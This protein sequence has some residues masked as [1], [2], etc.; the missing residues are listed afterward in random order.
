MTPQHPAPSVLVE[1]GAHA[2]AGQQALVRV[3]LRN[4]DAT[5]REMTLTLL[6]L[7]GE[8]LPVPVRT[9]PV[10]PDAT[11]SVDLPVRVGPGAV[12]GDYPFALAVQSHAPGV[13]GPGAEGALTMLEGSVRVDAPS[14]V[15]LA[16]EPADSTAVTGRRV[17]VVIANSGAQP[18]N[19]EL[20]AQAAKGMRVEV[21]GAW[22]RVPPHSTVRVPVRLTVLRP[23]LVGHRNRRAFSVLAR[24][25]Q[26]PGR[27]QGTL[28]SR[29]L[30]G[31]GFLRAVALLTVVAV[32][33]TGVV[34]GV[35]WL[36]QQV[37]QLQAGDTGP[38]DGPDQ[39]G[40][41]GGADGGGSEGGGSDGSG[42]GGGAEGPDVVPAAAEGVRVSGLVTGVESEGFTVRIAPAGQV[43]DPGAVVLGDGSPAD[44]EQA[45]TGAAGTA[46]VRTAVW[47]GTA[48]GPATKLAAAARPAVRTEVVEQTRTTSSLEDGTWA[49]AGLRPTA[50]YLVTLAKAGFQTQRFVLTG[51]QAAA[52][53]LEVEMVAGS[54]RL[55]GLVTGPD[56]PAGGVDV[57]ITDGTTTVT[58]S[59]ATEGPVGEW[60]VDGLSTPSTYLVTAAGAG[61]GAQSALVTL[62]AGGARTV[63]LTLRTGVASLAGVVSGPDALG[64]V[65]GLG[66]MTVTAT[67]G[68]TTRTASTATS[69]QVGAFVLA[70]LPV[71]A[72]YSVTV[73]GPGYAAT[74][75]EVTLTA[76]SDA[77][78]LDVSLG[79]STGVVQGTLVDAAG[80]GLGGAGLTLT[81]GENTYKT[82]STSDATGSFR[83]SGV[84]PGTYVLSA[85]LFGYVNG[86][87][88]VTV[89]A[90]GVATADLVLTDVPGDGLLA[91]SFIRGRV[92]DARTNGQITC[93]G[94]DVDAGETCEVT[95]TLQAADLDGATRT[96][97]VTSA[98]D[99]EYQIP[100]ADDP[101][102]GLLPG[103]YTLTVSAPGYE[104]GRVQVEVPMDQ[105]V[106]AAQVALFPSPSLVGTVLARVGTVPA[107]TCVLAVPAGQDLAAV[108]PCTLGVDADG[109][110]T[111]ELAGDARCAGIGVNGSYEMSRLRSGDYQVLVRPGDDEY[112]PVP[113]VTISL[114]PGD[115][116]RYDVTLDRR[117]RVAIT[118]LADTGTSALAPGAGAEVTP[119]RLV[120]GTETALPALTAGDDGRLL[121]TGL[122]AGTYRFDV[123]WTEAGVGTLEAS[124]PAITVG[125][126]QELSTQVVLTRTR[127]AFQGRVVTLL[128]SG[129]EAPASGVTV[130]VTGVTR[131]EGLTPVRATATV[132]TSDTGTFSVVP[133][134]TV[135][136]HTAVLPLA[137]DELSI[138]VTDP[139]L[140]ARF[141]TLTVNETTVSAV[142]DAPLVVEPVGREYVPTLRLVGN[143]LTGFDV[144]DVVLTV[145]SAPP[146]VTGLQLTP[147]DDGSGTGALIRWRDLAQ[148]SGGVTGGTLARPGDYRVT[149]TL[150]G[151]ETRTFSFTVPLADLPAAP[152]AI[153][154]RRFGELEVQVV[155]EEVVDN[156]PFLPPTTQTRPVPNPVVTLFRPAT[157]NITLTAAPGDNAV[158]FGELAPGTYQVRV[159]AP[160]FRFVT[161]DVVVPAGLADPVPFVVEKLGAITG[162][163]QARS[164]DGTL[165]TLA[166]VPV[167]ATDASGN[168]F[169]VT[170][171]ETG[172]YDITGTAVRQGLA[173]GTWTVTAVLPGYVMTDPAGFPAAVVEG[174]AAPTSV[175]VTLRAVPVD[176]RVF[177]FDPD[178]DEGIDGLSVVLRRSGQTPRTATP[179]TPTP[180]A[181]VCG[182]YDFTAVEP[183]RYTLDIS[184]GGYAPLTVPI[185]VPPGVPLTQ[186]DVPIAARPNT[187]GGTVLGQQGAGT[188]AAVDGAGIRLTSAADPA[189]LREAESDSAGAFSMTG[190]PDG[191]YTL[192]VSADGYVP[193]SRAVQ[194]SGGQVL[195][196]EVVLYVE[197]R[198]V[199]VTVTSVQGFDLTGALVQLERPAGAGGAGELP[200]AAQPVVRST[201]TTYTTTFNQVPAGEWRATVSGPSGHVGVFRSAVVDT[202]DTPGTAAVPVAVSVDEVRVRIAA[203][204]SGTAPPAALG[205]SVTSGS[206]GSQVTVA[207]GSAGVGAGADTVFLARGTAYTVRHTAV[208]GWAVDPPSVAVA[209]TATDVV[210]AFVLTP[211]L[212]TTTTALDSP[213]A[214][215]VLTRGTAATFRATVEAPSNQ[216]AEDMEGDTV[217][218]LLGGTVVGSATLANASNSRTRTAEVALT[219]GSTWPLGAAQVTARYVGT[220]THAASQSAARAVTVVAPTTTT[221]TAAAPSGTP[222]SGT[223]TVP[224]GTTVTLAA[225]VTPSDA[226]GRIVLS[227]TAPGPET[228][229][230][231]TAMSASGGTATT[232]VELTAAGTYTF[233]AAYD[234]QSAVTHAAS[235]ATVTVV[236]TA[237]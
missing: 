57:T 154:L 14:T 66:G 126:N 70:D 121:V 68:T 45:S 153:E 206:G 227:R 131:Y 31:S 167:T 9:A 21:D 193:T 92:S 146:G 106:R 210:V 73:S 118:V 232:T 195:A 159:Q 136:P 163:V 104:P 54:G 23:Q 55:S 202:A 217:D 130:Q 175:E 8:W 224:V 120:G 107:G 214:D 123:T 158:D 112:L 52:A 213:A 64:V 67:D 218:F 94:L 63:D 140:P 44:V 18:V 102:G 226:P 71:P 151:F 172:R 58:T 230:S 38:D 29:P 12:P 235:S 122:D 19:L 181:T 127:A 231:T 173:A 24:G 137:A 176:L 183:D 99:L 11:V 237:P 32:W 10:P 145:E 49:F 139:R 89:A 221:L 100:A 61:L 22:V 155:W 192:A 84:E 161:R 41:G 43:L 187:V 143:D 87:A 179:C 74:T 111:C 197:V 124:T 103:L 208:E 81:D 37:T 5:P 196:V 180:P 33:L 42:D 229:L 207:S 47:Q 115:V 2:A 91:T 178:T 134:F 16:V 116:R 51:V 34:V 105:V 4:L 160:G 157:G 225:A 7:D 109:A 17:A 6:G 199:A 78:R 132:T 53:P 113:P 204:A 148:P 46:D 101:A 201:A 119:V 3:H 169:T 125:T 189:F 77:A 191:S 40:G 135:A 83:I 88:P 215:A 26:S 182:L 234:R 220:S 164:A 15:V 200:L 205:W 80:T 177:V 72:T 236:V 98:P 95:V 59:T 233:R 141:E 86:Y 76:G 166:G 168:S 75:S 184:G 144:E 117:G 185:Q 50:T 212:I 162:T 142:E 211:D 194:V 65:G 190:V 82:M 28:T 20:S 93:P 133:S 114:T 56:G 186:I 27:T 222:T 25:D 152:L 216:T 30:L 79:V 165:R 150:G 149:A 97:S 147:V 203:T 174:R 128:A 170:S 223:L 39:R 60:S 13:G 85:E 62:A 138:Q 156:G 188:P 129:Q 228:E 90:G 110:P 198:Q 108:P 1:P 171:S 69:G 209:A 219:P 35:P 36:S 96:V 48:G